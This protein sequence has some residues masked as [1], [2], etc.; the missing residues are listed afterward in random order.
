MPWTERHISWLIGTPEQ[1]STSDG[2][3]IEVWEFR[4]RDDAAVMTAWA[5]HFRNHYCLDTQID[6]LRNSTGL[7][8]TAYLNTIKVP[9]AQTAPGPSIRAGDFTEILVADYLQYVLHYW[10]PRTRYA[11]KA[12]RNESTKGSDILGFKILQRGATSR[13]D[14]LAIFE[15]KAQLTGTTA[16]P[17][18]QDAIDDSIK[19]ELRKAESLNAIKQRL[20]DAGAVNDIATVERFQNFTD[21]PYAE[22]YGAVAVFSTSAYCE[23]MIATASTAAHPHSANLALM[24]IRGEDLM[25][26]VHQLYQRAA[27]EA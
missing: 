2:K 21:H 6:L 9:D 8:R 20:L 10:V 17:R 22:R 18:L 24:V 12:I 7:T 25:Q 19:D 4:H 13:R 11:D 5:K 3:A 1:V 26:L 23:H 16:K 27:N 15:T 14:E